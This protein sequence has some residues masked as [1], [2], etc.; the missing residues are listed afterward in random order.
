MAEWNEAFASP[1]DGVEVLSQG[2][3]EA[4]Y[5][6]E[7]ERLKKEAEDWGDKQGT[8]D[9]V[10]ILYIMIMPPM[11]VVDVACWCFCGLQIG[12]ILIVSTL[13]LALPFLTCGIMLEDA[14]KKTVTAALSS[15]V[16]I[17]ITISVLGIYNGELYRY[18]Q[19]FYLTHTSIAVGALLIFL[20]KKNDSEGNL[21]DNIFWLILLLGLIVIPNALLFVIHLFF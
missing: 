19:W 13:F 21:W 10:G 16:A 7:E 9:W 2:W 1:E 11:L 6:E 15:I 14:R 12:L 5:K 17:L 18:A 4:K 8:L 20:S 3:E